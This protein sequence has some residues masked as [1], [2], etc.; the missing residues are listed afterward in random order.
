MLASWRGEP[1]P[2]NVSKELQLFRG[3]FAGRGDPP[4]FAEASD[5]IDECC[6]VVNEWSCVGSIPERKESASGRTRRDPILITGLVNFV[7]QLIVK[8]KCF[9]GG[10][11][12]AG[13]GGGAAKCPHKPSSSYLF[14]LR[15]NV[16]EK[17]GGFGPIE[18]EAR[19]ELRL[20][21]GEPGAGGSDR[22]AGFTGHGNVAKLRSNLNARQGT[23]GLF[24]FGSAEFTSAK[25]AVVMFVQR[26]DCKNGEQGE[27]DDNSDLAR[28]A[29]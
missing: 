9:R 4:E 15:W 7:R 20:K 14:F 24:E 1:L 27:N 8:V 2:G 23:V 26:A 16:S 17:F 22:V 5:E 28:G 29:A 21:F 18:G 3:T 19:V 11:G 12:M 6:Q 25:P 13:L 10:L